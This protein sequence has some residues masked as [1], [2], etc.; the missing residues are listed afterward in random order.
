M[1]GNWVTLE[2][3][4]RYQFP[5]ESP[6]KLMG[7]GGGGAGAQ[8]AQRAAKQYK[9]VGRRRCETARTA[10]IWVK[11][12]LPPNYPRAFAKLPFPLQ[13]WHVFAPTKISNYLPRSECGY[14][15]CKHQHYK[16]L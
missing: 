16:F 9:K 14:S 3:H 6:H 1:R 5:A 10:L 7:G 4:N 8:A 12:R 11:I 13:R 15:H 2:L